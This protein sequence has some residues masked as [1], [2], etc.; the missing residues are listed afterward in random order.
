MAG[1][2][3][4]P[5]MNSAEAPPAFLI[6]KPGASHDALR[7]GGAELF[8]AARRPSIMGLDSK[9][10]LAKCVQQPAPT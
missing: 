9:I 5:L 10:R 7:S 4:D 8:E 2:V 1:I 6:G 3:S